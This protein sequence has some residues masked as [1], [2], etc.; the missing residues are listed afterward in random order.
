MPLLD[1]I[2]SRIANV[3]DIKAYVEAYKKSQQDR[4]EVVSPVY[5]AI[6]AEYT[7]LLVNNLDI[8]FNNPPSPTI[9]DGRQVYNQFH[10]FRFTV[11][12]LLQGPCTCTLGG[13]HVRN[14][15]QNR[16]CY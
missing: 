15:I 13:I 4:D 14:L 11:L 5:Q 3:D 9:A 16:R 7:R 12:T 8:C 10:T 2:P 1:Q 6:L